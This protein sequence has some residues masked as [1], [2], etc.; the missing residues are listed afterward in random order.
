M[1]KTPEATTPDFKGVS[2]TV[3]YDAEGEPVRSANAGESKFEMLFATGDKITVERKDLSDEM[4]IAAGWHGL[5]QKLGDS[6]SGQKKTGEDP[7]TNASAMLDQIVHGNWVAESKA[8]GPRIGLLVEAVVA[9]KT[10]AGLEV[11]EKAVAE[12]LKG[13]KEYQK[14]VRAN[15]QVDAE[16][17]RIEAERAAT[18]AKE[19]AT[20]AK[21]AD[22]ASL[23]D[24]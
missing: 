10:K 1:A 13:D 17:K 22:T 21:A 19:A 24:I 15:E 3:H 5:A 23:E 2:K 18:R 6:Y 12:R 8:S 16:Y 7:F 11:D 20:K 9:A 4:W 14:S